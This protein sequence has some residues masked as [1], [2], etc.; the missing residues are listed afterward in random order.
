MHIC[1]LLVPGNKFYQ[2]VL[3]TKWS[4]NHRPAKLHCGPSHT[5]LQ[6]HLHFIKGE[7]Y[8]RGFFVEQPESLLTSWQSL[9]DQVLPHTYYHLNN[10]RSLMSRCCPAP[11]PCW[12][13]QRLKQC[14][15]SILIHAERYTVDSEQTVSKFKKLK[16]FEACLLPVYITFKKIAKSERIGWSWA[17]A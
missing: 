5:A 4:L 3:S 9:V 17:T 10:H 7:Y 12:N 13:E 2:H 8:S 15:C 1:T 11:L 14:Q 16:L 6:I